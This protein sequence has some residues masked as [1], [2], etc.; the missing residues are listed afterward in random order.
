MSELSIKLKNIREQNGFTQEQVAQY[1]NVDQ[2]LIAKIESGE[3]KI[4]LGNLESLSS[5]YGVDL[6]TN[7]IGEPIK[8]AYRANNISCSDLETIAQIK[9]IALNL[10]FM[11][12][13][14]NDNR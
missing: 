11:E 8:V 4:Q 10:R 6:Q 5:L 2:S 14:K 12:N 7:S 1:L 3:R 9:R 13:L